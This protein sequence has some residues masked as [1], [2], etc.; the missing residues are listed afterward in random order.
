M[1]PSRLFAPALAAFAALALALIT[2]SHQAR[3]A[4]TVIV[5][6]LNER[7]TPVAVKVV[8]DPKRVAVLDIAVLDMLKS[9]GLTDR[10]VALSKATKVPGYEAEFADPKSRN[11]GSLVDVDLEGLM[12]AEP[13]VIFMSGRLLKKYPELSRIAPTIY[14]TTDRDA[15]SVESFKKNLLNVAKLFHKTDVAQAQ[16][17]EVEARVARIREH[18]GRANATALVGLITSAHV[19]LMGEKARGSIIGRELGFKNIAADANSNHGN[20]ASFELLLKLNPDYFFVIDRDSAIS[21][22]GAKVA[23]EILDN[24]LVNKMKAA[25]EGRIV[26]LTPVAWYLAEGGVEGMNDMLSDV[27]KA[28]GLQ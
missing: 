27:E 10:I 13:D 28:L 21:R 14:M 2:A 5:E 15:G 16:I 23:H 25:Q 11:V 22:K 12:A 7:M 1:R 8:D 9:W 17:A 3:A 24:P 4:E 6:S 18:A 20:E 26:Y 19:N